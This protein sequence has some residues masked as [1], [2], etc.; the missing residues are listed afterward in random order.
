MTEFVALLR[1]VN[2]GGRAPVR[3]SELEKV[4]GR[5]GLRHVRTALQ[6]GNLLFGAEARSEGS[7]EKEL[8]SAL[9][10]AL[11]L[12]VD[13][14]VR[15]AAAWRETVVR[16]PF[17]EEAA[18]DP[19]HLLVLFL[20]AAPTSEAWSR[21]AA[22]NR[23]RER[24]RPGDREAYIVYPDGIGRSQLTPALLEKALGVRGTGRNW[25]TVERLNALLFS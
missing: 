22:A 7:L 19:A 13:C 16:N 5:I 24:I 23:G 12:P 14:F 1:A 18:A 21:L 8:E 25:K 15:S 4:A 17:P 11:G 3:M 9:P 10:A 20:K 2:V 6:S